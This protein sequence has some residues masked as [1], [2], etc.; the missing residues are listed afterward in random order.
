M[1]QFLH[2][3]ATDTFAYQQLD[4]SFTQGIHSISGVNGASKSSIYL[5]LVQALYNRNPKGGKVDGINNTVTGRPSEITVTFR[6]G[7]DS[8]TVIN[9]RKEGKVRLFKNQKDVSLQRI[10]ETLKKIEEVLGVSYE[11][12]VDLTY[13]NSKSRLDLVEESG[14]AVRKA[15]VGKLLKFDELDELFEKVKVRG[16]EVAKEIAGY[17]K[18]IVTLTGSVSALRQVEDDL[19]TD[20]VQ[21]AIDDIGWQQTA[22]QQNLFNTKEQF[23]LADLALTAA[24]E[25]EEAN[26]LISELTEALDVFSSEFD[27]LE[28]VLE[29]Q[30]TG[31]VE[32]A[33][34]TAGIAALRA[35]PL[36]PVPAKP[37]EPQTVC[38]RCGQDLNVG[39]ATTIYQQD[40]QAWA[41]ASAVRLQAEAELAL[42]LN[43]L[44]GKLEKINAR[45]LVLQQEKSNWQQ[46]QRQE[47][48]LTQL[49]GT[50]AAGSIE[51]CAAQY[52]DWSLLVEGAQQQLSGITRQLSERRKELE[53]VQEHNTIQRMNREYNAQAEANNAKLG[54]QLDATKQSLAEAD[55]KLERLKRWQ[56]ILGPSGYRVSKMQRFLHLLNTAMHDYAAMISGGTINCRFYV[57]EEGKILFAVTD[58]DK[59]IPFELWSD[60]EKGRVKLTCLFAVLDLLESMGGSSFNLL[61]LDEVFASLDAAGREGLFT[62]LEHLKGRGKSIYTIA[63]SPIA[64]AVVFDSVIEVVKV[65]GLANLERN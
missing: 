35:Q 3:K 30:Q 44:T 7:D 29:R 22:A 49:R 6:K 41:A 14:D 24:R 25:S 26:Q 12:F 47:A 10:P 64:N 42:Q 45:L 13:H 4:F 28:A 40:L 9:S 17:E 16:K 65:G 1:I 60:G 20:A 55:A 2:I 31:E 27:S 62:V 34:V 53:A 23:R 54:L 57:S 15:F 63:H 5:A 39:Q 56:A 21:A 59:S 52:A 37:K 51:E 46:K 61:V 19:D 18:Q 11:T 58:A 43:K 48:E 8:Y 32:K 38:D 33:K 36:P 50:V